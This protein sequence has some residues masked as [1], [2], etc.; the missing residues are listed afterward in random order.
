[1]EVCAFD[2]VC[3]VPCGDV[4]TDS[5]I[6]KVIT[7]QSPLGQFDNFPI[8]SDTR[9]GTHTSSYMQDT[10]MHIPF[11]QHF[12]DI[13]FVHTADCVFSDFQSTG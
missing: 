2:E 5:N 11:Y 3:A 8:L 10:N 13:I 6:W 9:K 1:M 12:Q 7:A 4:L